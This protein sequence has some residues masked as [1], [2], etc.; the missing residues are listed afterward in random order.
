MLEFTL[1]SFLNEGIDFNEETKEVSYNPYHQEVV[2]TSE[3][4]NPTFERILNV[5]V[6]S[7]FKRRQGSESQNG[8]PLLFAM[9]KERGWKF[10]SRIDETQVYEQFDKI[11]RKFAKVHPIGLTIIIPSSNP[12]NMVLAKRIKSL[13]SDCEIITNV[14]EKLT[15]DDIEWDLY[16]TSYR[17]HYNSVSFYTMT[18]GMTKEKKKKFKE[19]LDKCLG[20][21]RTKNDGIFTFHYLTPELRKHFDKSL[22]IEEPTFAENAERIN[23]HDILIIDDNVSRG[24]T[25][26]NAISLIQNTFLPKSIKALTLFSK[27]K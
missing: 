5:E 23:G 26:I 11:V 19:S 24:K 9:K 17:E 21:M 25:M 22:K 13:V 2:D 15:V 16:E 20:Q 4:S 1:P 14:F 27:A 8:N 7:I 6:F 3:I 12:L 18:E 10:K